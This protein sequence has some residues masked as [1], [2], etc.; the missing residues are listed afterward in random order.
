M[1]LSGRR[2]R[3]KLATAF[4]LAPVVG[5]VFAAAQ[6]ET[7]AF[8]HDYIGTEHVLL[9]L[10]G[11]DDETGRTL[12]GFGLTLAC[13][14]ADTRRIVGEGPVPKRRSTPKRSTRSASICKPCVNVS[15]RPSARARWNARR[16]G[17]EPAGRGL[18]GPATPQA[19]PRESAARRSSSKHATRRCRCRARPGTAAGLGRGSHS[20]RA[21]HIPRAPPRS[22]RQTRHF[23]VRA[24]CSLAHT[25]ANEARLLEGDATPLRRES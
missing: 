3:N 16:V 7:V 19:G 5:E 11:R 13:V 2:R 14:R 17:G 8:R 15:K 20:R 10:V 18:Q 6:V 9:A 1:M 22:A 4:E 25:V 23:G 24:R 12:R 21:R